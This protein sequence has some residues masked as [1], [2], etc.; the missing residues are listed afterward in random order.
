[1]RFLVIFALIVGMAGGIVV[2]MKWAGHAQHQEDQ[3]WTCGMHPQV[4]ESKPGQCPICGMALTPVKS[5]QANKGPTTNTNAIAI[6]PVIVQNMGVRVTSVT[7]GPVKRHIRTVGFLEEAQP[8]IRD[9]NLRVSG[10]IEKLYAN[11]EGV[12]VHKGKPLF[13]LYSPEIQ[14]ATEELIIARKGLARITETTDQMTR[15]T[16]QGLYDAAKR[17]LEQW[18]LE[19][20]Q[21][22]ELAK[23]DTAPRAIAFLSPVTGHITEKMVVEGASVG[24][25]ERALRIV[26]HE[27]LWL[28]AQIHAQDHPF[29]KIGQKV[30]ATIE[31]VPG[32]VF[33]GEAIFV[34]PHVDMMTRTARLRI[35]VPTPE[36]TLKP[37]MFAT[38][39]IESQI[40]TDAILVPRDAVID[41]GSRQVVFIAMENGHF[42][43]RDLKLG[44]SS[45][46]GNVQVLEGLKPG[47]QVVISGQF[48]IDSESRMAEAIRKH[49]D[50]QLL[51]KG[52]SSGMIAGSP[53]WRAGVDE[54]VNAYLAI[55]G[56]LGAVQ[57]SDQPMAV[58]SL[59]GSAKALVGLIE[60]DVQKELAHPI[61]HAAEKMV[62]QSLTD[63]RNSFKAV[64]DSTIALVR[65]SPPTP[66]V[67]AKLYLWH[68]PMTNGNWLQSTDKA[69][70][71]YY[72]TDMKLCAELKQTIATVP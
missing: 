69:A 10:W 65:R 18:G 41:T 12:H 36:M 29:I 54:V 55:E 43:P 26:D 64:S 47:E 3:L 56:Q 51:A 30:A 37:G 33:E 46:D 57:T 14:V 63:Q 72:A 35:A 60:S 48:L 19:A 22:D 20:S 58:E 39:Q 15:Q 13:D 27:L 42:E 40:V 11:T 17:K 24:A 67:G 38:V 45:D 6:D 59:L 71:P 53:A 61:L 70:N 1:M 32:K 31:A 7:T 8:N 28:D 66:A 21:I 52:G 5:G 44:S 16:T 62:G 23:L 50:R 68:C 25:G 4:I 34:H 2:G 9:I 49:L